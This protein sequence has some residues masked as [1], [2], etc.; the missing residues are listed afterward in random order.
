MMESITMCAIF[1]F[2]RLVK[3]M[4][5]DL[6]LILVVTSLLFRCLVFSFFLFSLLLLCRYSLAFTIRWCEVYKWVCFLLFL[7]QYGVWTFW[8]LRCRSSS[9]SLHLLW[10]WMSK[11]LISLRLQSFI[12][13]LGRKCALEMWG[14][15]VELVFFPLC[16]CGFVFYVLGFC[17]NGQ[18]FVI[19]ISWI[20]SP[21]KGD[22]INSCLHDLFLHPAS[23]QYLFFSS[24]PVCKSLCLAFLTKSVMFL[25][26]PAV[27]LFF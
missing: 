17:L 25:L 23:S 20:I 11:S 24:F 1:L 7:L 8:Y 9:I 3:S 22:I 2:A 27:S 4:L 16:V 19:L 10:S 12:W 5:T 13:I 18:C 21:S 6:T 15:V 14:L 26:R